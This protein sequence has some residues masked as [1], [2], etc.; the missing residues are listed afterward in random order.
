[1]NDLFWAKIKQRALD[2]VFF[3]QKNPLGRRRDRRRALAGRLSQSTVAL[4]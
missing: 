4:L 1:L 2:P 3:P